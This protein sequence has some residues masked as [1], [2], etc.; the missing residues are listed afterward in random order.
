MRVVICGHERKESG[1]KEVTELQQFLENNEYDTI[2]FTDHGPNKEFEELGN[3]DVM[4]LILSRTSPDPLSA[5][6]AYKFAMD[7]KPVIIYTP[8]E[9]I[10]E[11]E[12][13]STLIA[14]KVCRSKQEL[15][16]SIEEFGKLKLKT[17][18]LISNVH[19]DHE[20]EF[21][22]ND[23]EC[24]C[25]VTG[26]RDRATI[27]IAYAPQQWLM[28]YESLDNYFKQFANR[29]IH[30]EGVV[31]EIFH[32][33]NHTIQPKWI[34]VVAEFEPRSGVKATVEKRSK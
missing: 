26:E 22:Y 19:G 12:F 34:K 16:K 21:E 8:D 2:Q 30:H 24:I 23:F 27:K 13:W 29:R 25:P 10:P 6:K 4:V 20:A 5:V 1:L 7:T 33:L 3:S 31:N 9:S 15:L 18:G 32:Q 28:E 11:L 14:R 17:V